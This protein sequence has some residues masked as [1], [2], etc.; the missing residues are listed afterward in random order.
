MSDKFLGGLSASD[1]MTI[2]TAR[3]LPSIEADYVE[4]KVELGLANKA[5]A[6]AWKNGKPD[7]IKPLMEKVEKAQWRVNRLKQNYE[8]AYACAVYVRDVMG[9]KP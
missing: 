7:Q 3:D 1:I 2:G 8:H 6:D 5:V 4:A 9:K